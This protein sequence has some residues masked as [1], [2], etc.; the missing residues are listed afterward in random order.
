MLLLVIP[1]NSRHLSTFH[2][3][4]AV[5]EQLRRQGKGR[6]IVAAAIKEMTKGFRRTPIA[7]FYIK[8]V[9]GADN[10]VSHKI[11]SKVLS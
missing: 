6:D 8:A 1:P 9:V 10:E 3:G 5:P 11:A 7:T 4:Y 2:L